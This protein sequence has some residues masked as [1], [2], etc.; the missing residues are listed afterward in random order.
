MK[1]Y[2]VNPLCFLERHNATNDLSV[3][4]VGTIMVQHLD[5]QSPWNTRINE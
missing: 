1:K 3:P 4:E 2:N 5:M